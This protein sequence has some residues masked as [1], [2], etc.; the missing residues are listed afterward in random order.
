M[1]SGPS[2]R[3]HFKRGSAVL[4][5]N[6]TTSS[7]KTKNTG[8][9]DRAFEQ[10]LIDHGV[11]PDGYRYPGGKALPKPDN[12]H[13]IRRE[14]ARPRACFSPT[15]FTDEDFESFRNIAI[16]ARKEGGVSEHVMPILEGRVEDAGC[17]NGKIPFGN[18]DHLTDKTLVA[19]NPDRYYG[20]RPEQLARQVRTQLHQ[21]IVPSTDGS[22]PIVPNFFFH[23]KGPDGT[24]TATRRQVCYDGALGARG[25]HKLQAYSQGDANPDNNAYTL[26]LSYY[27]GVLEIYSIHMLPS[28]RGVK[29]GCEYATTH[30]GGYLLTSSIESFQAGVCAYRNA[31]DWAEKQRNEAI[32]QANQRFAAAQVGSN[33]SPLMDDRNTGSNVDFH[34]T[35]SSIT[36][37]D[38][39]EGE[40]AM[41]MPVLK[42]T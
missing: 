26:A 6:P 8:P 40:K 42:R 17:V 36:Y 10:N 9:Y 21:Y 32:R 23:A 31:R 7:S 39:S 11:Y 35:E 1:S 33:P 19:G 38:M 29:P 2:L 37:I 34:H 16:N 15:S 22:L 5:E 13:E 27:D 14:L 25:I 24:V 18:L 3:G 30:V 28:G 41:E 4:L 20:A 12:L